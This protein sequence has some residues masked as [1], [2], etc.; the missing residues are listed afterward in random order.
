MSFWESKR[1]LVTGGEGFLGSFLVEK[2]KEKKVDIFVPRFEDY[3]LRRHDD[4]NKM[5]EDFLGY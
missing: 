3:D 5:F 1:V 2:L 4:I